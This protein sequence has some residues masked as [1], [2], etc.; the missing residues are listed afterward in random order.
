MNACMSSPSLACVPLDRHAAVPFVAREH[1]HARAAPPTS[2]PAPRAGCPAAGRR[3][4]P[5]RGDS[6]PLSAGESWNVTRLSSATPVSAVFRFCRLRTNSPAPNSSRKL[7]ATCAATRPLRR[8]SDPPV[9]AIEPTVSFSVVHGSGRLARSAGSS[10]NTRPVRNVRPSVNARIRGVRLRPN[11]DRLAVRRDEREQP[12][13]QRD[14]QGDAQQR[15]RRATAP[16]SRPASAA[17]AGRAT[18]RATAA[19]QSPSAA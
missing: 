15:R 12:L 18:R 5:P 8:N 11:Q 9:P 14:R 16:G 6:Y 7:S 17:P 13:R 19:P 10:P 2:R 3:R 4:P 1:R